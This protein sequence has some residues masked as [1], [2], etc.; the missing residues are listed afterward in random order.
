M[1]VAKLKTLAIVIL[2][3]ANL[4]LLSIL[5]PT[6]IEQQQEEDALR[7]SLSQ[8]FAAESITLDPDSIPQ[9]I[10]LYELE[11]GENAA[12]DEKAATA[13][14]G[15]DAQLQSAASRY[16]RTY[17][18]AAGTCQINRSGDFHAQLA[19]QTTVDSVTASAKKYLKNMGFSYW[20]VSDPTAQDNV[21]TVSATQSVLDVPIFSSTLTLTY[22]DSRLTGVRGVFFTGAGSLFRISEEACCSAADALVAFLA[23]RYTLGWVGSRITN[24]TQGYLQSD[25][26]AAAAV[27]L[28][29]VWCISTDTGLFYVNGLTLE[30]T[31]AA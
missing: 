2:L 28:T 1:P 15:Q 23:D 10:T 30:I 7:Q 21:C 22:T 25:T 11:L 29:P 12:A 16:R 17:Q 24:V 5:I 8:L 4:L 13:L 6:R 19:G 20:S 9:E 31:A 26:A 18:S 27:R 14:L 3:A